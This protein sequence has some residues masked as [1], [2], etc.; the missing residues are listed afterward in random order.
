MSEQEKANIESSILNLEAHSKA[1]SAEA[2][3]LRKQLESESPSKKKP[4]A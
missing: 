2:A 3:E 1:L 4:K